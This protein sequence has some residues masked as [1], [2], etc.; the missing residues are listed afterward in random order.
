MPVG[1]PTLWPLTLSRSA[2]LAAKST[3]TWPTAW[4][5]S[6]WK[7]IPAA[8]ATW[9]SWAT[10]M[11]VPTSLLAHMTL[12][13]ATSAADAGPPIASAS[14]AAPTRPVASPPTQGT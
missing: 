6:V 13:R 7:G 14:A 8:L 9:A 2:P 4:T 3:S 12:T 10:G 5:A 1:P 11:T